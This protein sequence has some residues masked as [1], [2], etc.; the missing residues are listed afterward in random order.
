MSRNEEVRKQNS[1]TYLLKLINLTY[2]RFRDSVANAKSSD[3]ALVNL[4]FLEESV[5]IYVLCHGC[6]TM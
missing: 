6:P 5:T 2:F 4:I 1:E 3:E